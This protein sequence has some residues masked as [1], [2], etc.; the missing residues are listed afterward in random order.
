MDRGFWRVIVHG[1]EYT[2][3]KL[4]MMTGRGRGGYLSGSE[5]LAAKGVMNEAGRKQA[6]EVLGLWG[7]QQLGNPQ[8][9]QTQK[10]Q[11]TEGGGLLRVT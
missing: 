11:S 3:F 9:G 4:I 2:I 6:Y 5:N 1:S 7:R 10:R 8:Y